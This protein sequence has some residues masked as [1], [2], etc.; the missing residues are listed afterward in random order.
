M[1]KKIQWLKVLLW[2]TLLNELIYAVYVITNN[3]SF[4]SIYYYSCT[5]TMILE[6]F[7]IFVNAFYFKYI[8]KRF[9]TILSICVFIF[10]FIQLYS[11]YING[12]FNISVVSRICIWPLLF[13]CFYLGSKIDKELKYYK[14]TIIFSY[15]ALVL[16]SIPA[17]ILH[18]SGYGRIGTLIFTTYPVLTCTPLLVM[19]LEKKYRYK[20]LVFT[21]FYMILTTKRTAVIAAIL[22]LIIYYL[23]EAV[24]QNNLK[25]KVYKLI[26]FFLWCLFAFLVVCVINYFFDLKII[27]RFADLAS[28]GGSGRDGI[29][30]SVLNAYDSNTTIQQ[31]IGRGY[32]GVSRIVR[33]QHRAIGAH[34]DFIEIIY[35]FGK[36]GL[37]S[38]IMFYIT[39]I[40]IGIGMIR[41]KYNRA[42][43][44]SLVIVEMIILSMFSYL[45]IQSYIIQNLIIYIG[46]ELR[47]YYSWRR[48]KYGSLS[49]KSINT[50]SNL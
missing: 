34:N 42:P 38:I 27:E 3:V 19:V 44:F 12:V 40:I 14:N 5:L 26:K 49:T 43:L 25:K 20:I 23:V 46:L 22:G 13:F 15:V 18:L 48:N 29:W 16:I 47:Y 21:I 28:D 4:S 1:L 35:D 17:I 30:E 31:L 9:T 10:L 32:E 45:L 37:F 8:K 24:E 7:Y 50:S 33:P 11:S 39:L 6:L 41:L 2:A 36:I